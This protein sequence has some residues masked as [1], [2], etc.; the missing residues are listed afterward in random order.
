M[1][2]SILLAQN[3]EVVI[4]D[5]G[6]TDD[7]GDRAMRW[8]RKYPRSIK[9]IRKVNGGPASARNVG[10][11]QATGDWVTFVDADDFVGSGYFA[12]VDDFISSTTDDPCLI[13]GNVRYF[14]ERSKRVIDAHPLRFRFKL[15]PCVV[16]VFR[17]PTF[18]HLAAAQGFYK[19]S[20]IENQQLRFS[21]LV[22]PIFE[23]AHFTAKYLCLAPTKNVAFL[24]HAHYYYT[25]R[26]DQ[27]SLVAS[28]W[29]KPSR[30]NELLRHGYLDILTFA[31]GRYGA[32]PKYIQNLVLYDLSWMF[33]RLVDHD[34]QLKLLGS[35][36]TDRFIDLLRQILQLIDIETVLD[37][38]ITD[39]PDFS[40]C[41]IIETLM[42]CRIENALINVE[43]YDRGS[44]CVRL[45][46]S[47]TTETSELILVDDKPAKPHSE[48]TQTHTFAGRFFAYQRFVNVRLEKGSS[49][50]VSTDGKPTLIRLGLSRLAEVTAHQIT[51]QEK[52]DVAQGLSNFMPGWVRLW[53]R[54]ASVPSIGGSY[55]GAWLLMDRDVQADDN[56]EHLYRH[57][58]QK[59]PEISAYF[60]LRRNSHDW[61]RLKKEGFKLLAFGS[62]NH[63]LAFL[64]CRVLASSH[65]DGYIVNFLPRKWFGDITSH[66]FVFL[67]HGVT[68]GD[69]STW[70]NQK[71]LDCMI[72][73]GA[74]EW[75]SIVLDKSRYRFSKQEVHLTGFPRFDA[76]IDKKIDCPKTILIMPTWRKY[77]V[78]EVKG[79]T[80]WR[81]HRDGFERTQYAQTW[82]H[83]LNNA[84]LHEL[85][86]RYGY[87]IV[88][89]PHANITPYLEKFR[90]APVIEVF[91]HRDGSI[92]QAF[93]SATVLVTDYSSVAF[94]VAYMRRAVLYY[95]F[96]KDEFY[97]GE[98]LYSQG[99]FDHSRD[100][101]GPCCV[102]EE[103]LLDQLTMTLQNGGIP[104]PKYCE[105]MERFFPH[106]DNKNSERVFDVIVGLLSDTFGRQ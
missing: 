70:I 31:R 72:T 78:G 91:T 64:K 34:A 10:L 62:T 101:F 86:F 77:V 32:V 29:T 76:L 105:R 24:P 103:Q 51:E 68:E 44:G 53:R 39:L 65:I 90:L 63:K 15:G 45:S 19:R 9:Y 22:V 11:S 52:V 98:H 85:A 16:D 30:F 104:E 13:C 96:D 87:R 99:Y 7:T 21:E 97:S 41:G 48:K 80:N 33:Q 58:M 20:L 59:H 84:T 43:S 5:D 82:Q 71:H 75:K 83:L 69:I 74:P 14:Y 66:K 46:R 38:D 36:G 100:G 28:A 92:Q 94:D 95:Q 8:Q 25:K 37:F 6:S 73:A 42:G 88:F 54:I 93:A 12:A 47:F 106:R 40:K 57:L 49:C 27:S 3:I 55:K 56:A 1:R 61:Q 26:Q 67:Q 79:K 102:S 81:T 50:R 2:Q 17:S 18:L 4:V 60:V 35:K 89:F 23:D